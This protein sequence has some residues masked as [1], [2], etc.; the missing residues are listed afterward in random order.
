VVGDQLLEASALDSRERAVG[1]SALAVAI[2]TAAEMKRQAER[3]ELVGGRVRG[4]RGDIA[5]LGEADGRTVEGGLPGQSGVRICKAGA[6][7]AG[8]R[9]TR[10]GSGQRNGGGERGRQQSTSGRR[11]RGASRRTTGN[12]LVL[13]GDGG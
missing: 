2:T 3:D 10:G 6:W 1:G 13:V 4:V 5:K 9:G 11:G 12:G 7:V 8:G